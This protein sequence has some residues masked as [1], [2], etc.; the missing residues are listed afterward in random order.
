MMKSL[1]ALALGT[2]ERGPA[3]QRTVPSTLRVTE[4]APDPCDRR[5]QAST[6]TRKLPEPVNRGIRLRTRQ[7][8]TRESATSKPSHAFMT[9][10]TSKVSRQS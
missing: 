5:A 1:D 7:A 9:S 10:R 4:I 3:E 8:G 2:S 6:V